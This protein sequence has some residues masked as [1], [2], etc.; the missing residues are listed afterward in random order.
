VDVRPDFLFG[1]LDF[2][3]DDLRADFRERPLDVFVL[4]LPFW[5]RFFITVRAATSSARPP[6]RPDFLAL[7][8]IFSY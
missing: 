7:R 6:Y 5:R 8:F 2:R 3:P 4:A 1:P